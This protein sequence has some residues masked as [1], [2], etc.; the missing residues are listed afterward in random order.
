MQGAFRFVH[1]ISESPLPC[2]ADGFE[3]NRHAAQYNSR[4][5][6]PTNEP[7]DK[8]RSKPHDQW[9][10]RRHSLR[11]T[12]GI[13]V[14]FPV[15]DQQPPDFV[16]TLMARQAYIKGNRR[17]IIESSPST[18]K[19]HCKQVFVCS[20]SFS[21]SRSEW[22]L[23]MPQLGSPSLRHTSKVSTNK[24]A[25]RTRSCKT[26]TGWRYPTPRKQS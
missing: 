19:S 12:M 24:P 26:S 23:R 1:A 17:T 15:R 2:H 18:V 5:E 8:P 25:A 11:C 3:L 14:D 20:Y 21:R 4:A 22:H 10:A 16:S 9:P 13:I 6:P 7:P